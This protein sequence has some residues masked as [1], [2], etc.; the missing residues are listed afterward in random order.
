M[1]AI[2]NLTKSYGARTIL[3]EVNY[4]FPDGEKIALVGPNGAGKTTLLN[5]ISGTESVDG[6]KIL[7]SQGLKL[8]Y[9]PQEPESNPLP[10]VLEECV[11]G[12]RTISILKTRMDEALEALQHDIS[13]AR[14]SEFEK[15]ESQ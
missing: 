10:T 11:G 5:I 14:I 2:E 1:L 12:H 4:R 6:G 15:A 13:D 8:G 9:L 7:S 3:S